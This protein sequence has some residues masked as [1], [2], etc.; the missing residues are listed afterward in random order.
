MRILQYQSV[1]ALAYRNLVHVGETVVSLRTIIYVGFVIMIIPRTR[2]RGNYRANGGAFRTS[3]AANHPH[4][5]L[6]LQTIGTIVVA[7]VPT[8]GSVNLHIIVV[9]PTSSTGHD[10]RVDRPFPS[11]LGFSPIVAREGEMV[12]IDG[13]LG[14]AA[15]HPDHSSKGAGAGD[16]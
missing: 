9:V 15:M 2:Q 6:I 5:V 8:F 16:G 14:Y 10:C 1:V 7:L 12:V 3:G 4:I 11:R 13:A